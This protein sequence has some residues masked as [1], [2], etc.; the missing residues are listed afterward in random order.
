MTLFRLKYQSGRTSISVI[1]DAKSVFHYWSDNEM[2]TEHIK[3]GEDI[4]RINWR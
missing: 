4:G 2:I 1:L 3:K